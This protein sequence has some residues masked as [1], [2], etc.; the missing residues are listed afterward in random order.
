MRVKGRERRHRRIIKKLRGTEVKPRLVVFRSKKHI[1]AQ[2]VNDTAQRVITGCSTLT[3]DL[4]EVSV[5]SGERRKAKAKEV[6][7]LLAQKALKLGVKEICFD[8]AGYKYHGR[9]KAL[10]EGA[11]DGGL[12]F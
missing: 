10:A 9:V 12:K 4:K 7:R 3:K 5:E 2:I 11:R 1:Y 6:G 8:R